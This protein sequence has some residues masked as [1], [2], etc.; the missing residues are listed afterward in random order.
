M[1][2]EPLT[3]DEDTSVEGLAYRLRLLIGSRSTRSV[4]KAWDLSYSTLNNYLNRG[5]EPSLS[6]AKKIADREGVSVEWLASGVHKELPDLTANNPDSAQEKAPAGDPL[7]FAWSMVFTSLDKKDIAALLK[8]IHKE[9]VKGILHDSCL[10]SDF[11]HQ[12]YS[13]SASQ[14]ERF[15]AQ[16]AALIDEIKHTYGTK[17]E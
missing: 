9:G 6:M 8:V 7:E 17:D 4:A 13:L 16:A 2:N 14:R 5:T 12:L 10:Q 3:G 1:K 15:Y 11:E